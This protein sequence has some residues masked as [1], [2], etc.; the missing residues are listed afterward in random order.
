MDNIDS[1]LD[2]SLPHLLQ[3]F[4]VSS[5]SGSVTFIL[6]P[7]AMVSHNMLDSGVD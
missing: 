5:T 6:K 2:V 1:V 7:H 3:E 4:Q